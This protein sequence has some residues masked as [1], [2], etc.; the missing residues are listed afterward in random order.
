MKN[1]KSRI[2]KQSNH[3]VK[4]SSARGIRKKSM[5]TSTTWWT[6]A[7]QRL[8]VNQRECGQL[9][10]TTMMSWLQQEKSQQKLDLTL[11][12]LIIVY[13]HGSA[14]KNS[15]HVWTLIMVSQIQKAMVVTSIPFTHPTV[16]SMILTTSSQMK[17]AVHVMEDNRAQ[18]GHGPSTVRQLPSPTGGRGARQNPQS[19]PTRTEADSSRR[20]A[21]K[22]PWK[23]PGTTRS[24]SARMKT[25]ANQ[26]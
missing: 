26:S 10:L 5:S 4:P 9:Q 2:V 16:A 7:T 3:L 14:Q 23:E 12:I 1:G 24:A 11:S 25:N 13:R 15:R 17:C 6:S 22:C 20:N 18:Y 19:P 21:S 8:H